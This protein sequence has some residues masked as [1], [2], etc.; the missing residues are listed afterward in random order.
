MDLRA[1]LILFIIFIVCSTASAVPVVHSNK[2]RRKPTPTVNH[3]EK[4]TVKTPVNTPVH[5]PIKPPVRRSK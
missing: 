4:M 2:H 5:T 3:Q 1:Y